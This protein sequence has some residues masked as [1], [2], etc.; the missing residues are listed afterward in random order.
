LTVPAMQFTKIN[1]V[2]RHIH[3]LEPVQVPRNNK[4][5]FCNRA[6]VLVNK[7]HGLL[8]ANIKM[9]YVVSYHKVLNERH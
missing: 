3:L 6:K 1:K 8:N 4:F 5:N 9:N 2:M 7:W